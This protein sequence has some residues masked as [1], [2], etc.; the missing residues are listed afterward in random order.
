MKKF[1][2]ISA[3]TTFCL[4][5]AEFIIARKIPQLAYSNA[6]NSSLSCLTKSPF[7]AFSLDKNATCKL[8]NFYGDYD[9][10][11]HTNSLGYRS[12][13]FS[14]IKKKD[15]NRILVLG[16]SFTFGLGVSDDLTYPYLLE[17]SLLQKGLKNSEVINAGYVG[18]FSP[19]GY[20]VYLKQYG[21]KLSPDIIIL[22][23]FIYN[24]IADLSETVW[25]QT[26]DAGLPEVVSSC[27]RFFDQ[28]RWR[29]KKMSLKYRIPL[30]RN[31]QLFLLAFNEINSRLQLRLDPT[32]EGVLRDLYPGCTLVPSC[33]D[34]FAKQEEKIYRVLK[35]IRALSD[36]QKVKLLVVLIPPQYQLMR[37]NPVQKFNHISLDENDPF[38]LQKRLGLFLHENNIR[39]LDLLPILSKDSDPRSLYFPHDAHFTPRGNTIAAQAI[40]DYL[41]D[42][43]LLK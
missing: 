29:S 36:K 42:H 38:F 11:A 37:T 43:K 26:D 28:G 13:E 22:G 32:V 6:Y 23:F 34:K 21:M 14:E 40:S 7:V 9:T 18:G 16:D 10:V 1:F 39:Y 19:D 31:S 5:L 17:K 41:I 35:G 30:L 24:D 20:Y 25:E 12:Q 8:K 2:L 15:I 27:C 3:A 33:I 4:F